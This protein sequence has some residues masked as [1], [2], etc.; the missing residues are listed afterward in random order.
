MSATLPGRP[1]QALTPPIAFLELDG[2]LSRMGC[3]AGSWSRSAR[4]ASRIQGRAM[5]V[6]TRS[7]WSQSRQRIEQCSATLGT[8]LLSA[9]NGVA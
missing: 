2:V 5:P 6:P 8:G 4:G 3:H 7:R 9:P 1:A